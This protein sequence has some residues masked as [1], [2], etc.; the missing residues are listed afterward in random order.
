MMFSNISGSAIL[1][2]SFIL[3]KFLAINISHIFLLFPSLF[4]FWYFNYTDVE[5]F[6]IAQEFLDILFFLLCTLVSLY[7]LVCEISTDISSSLL[8]LSLAVSSL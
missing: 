8:I 7:I 2:L 3:K 6:E 5:R 4:F 1:F